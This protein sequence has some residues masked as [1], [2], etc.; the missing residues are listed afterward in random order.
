M[1]VVTGFGRT[2][3]V[4]LWSVV[5]ACLALTGCCARLDNRGLK[6]SAC[7]QFNRLVQVNQALRIVNRSGSQARTAVQC[8]DAVVHGIPHAMTTCG[9][10]RSRGP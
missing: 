2:P 6:P 9:K 5:E 7:R 8:R 4:S 10:W 3:G 1:P